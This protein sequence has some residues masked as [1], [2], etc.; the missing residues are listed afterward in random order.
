MTARLVP[1]SAQSTVNSSV[2]AP[3]ATIDSPRAMITI[4]PWRST[5]WPGCTVKPATPLMY[6]PM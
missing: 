2:P 3:M 5:K 4:N 6:G 1:A